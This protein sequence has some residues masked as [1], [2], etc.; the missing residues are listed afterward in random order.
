M[1]FHSTTVPVFVYKY[2]KES[3]PNKAEKQ[4]LEEVE[5]VV[6]KMTTLVKE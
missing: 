1:A 5:A 6:E 2:K 4:L 3:N